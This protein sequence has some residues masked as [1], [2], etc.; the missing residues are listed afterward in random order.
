[1]RKTVILGL[2]ALAVLAALSQSCGPTVPA[3]IGPEL[4]VDGGF[5]SGLSHW[6]TFLMNGA[7]AT[8]TSVNGAARI[9]I[10]SK[11]DVSSGDI[12]L[13]QPDPSF[14]IAG[15]HTYRLQFDGSSTTG[16]TFSVSIDENGY[17]INNDGFAYSAHAVG[18]FTLTGS[19]AQ[20]QQD[21]TVNADNAHAGIIFLLGH[22]TGDIT[23]DNVS[24]RELLQ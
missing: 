19:M 24:L 3:T 14:A 10:I 17:D 18:Q 4:I 11:N 8:F 16:T 21:L 1:M 5:S 12:Q 2:F 22:C 9:S 7:S 6:S 13:S 15:G 20:Y 23:L